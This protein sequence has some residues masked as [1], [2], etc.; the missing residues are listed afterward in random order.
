MT[1]RSRQPFPGPPTIEVSWGEVIDKMTI[2]EIKEQRL[3][4]PEAVAHVRR[5][6]TALTRV[7]KK[8]DPPPAELDALT[9]R[10]KSVNEALWTIEDQIRAKEAS[11]SF[12][13]QFVELARSIYLNN[14]ERSRLKR[15]I[16]E[17][18]GSD[19]VEEKQYTPYR[20]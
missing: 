14:D 6:R 16:N 3:A 20:S 19:L 17:L 13:R 4:S 15:R 18:L 10:L 8:L 5:E 9:S 12:D 7:L 1:S 11:K 2:L